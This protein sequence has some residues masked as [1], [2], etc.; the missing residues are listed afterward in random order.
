MYE[1]YALTVELKNY[2]LTIYQQYIINNF[3]ELPPVL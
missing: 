3:N 2:L 1:D